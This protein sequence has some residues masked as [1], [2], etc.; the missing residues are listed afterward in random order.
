M[1]KTLPS[2]YD[3]TGKCKGGLLESAKDST[4]SS[5]CTPSAMAGTTAA[6]AVEQPMATCSSHQDI[7]HSE[8]ETTRSSVRTVF[9]RL[10]VVSTSSDCYPFSSTGTA[11]VTTSDRK[12]EPETSSDS[13]CETEAEADNTSS[14]ERPPKSKVS[15]RSIVNKSVV[16]G[17]SSPLRKSKT[18][19]DFKTKHP[20]LSFDSQK[21]GAYY[22]KFCQKFYSGERGL[23][24]GSDGVFITKPFT[25]WFKATG[26]T[27]KNNRLLKHQESQAHKLAISQAELCENMTRRGSVYTQLYSCGAS[28]S[29]RCLNLMMLC[30]YIK[31]C[32]LAT[33]T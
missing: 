10:S 20:W 13:L 9:R 6:T 18:P 25:K 26:S 4:T 12:T 17:K 24:K 16:F 33:K 22:C 2:F 14:E 11:S 23:P 30:K 1:Q 29:D 19:I 27:K 28:D 5:S 7:I 21:K 8:E 15:K 3:S 32:L 31:N